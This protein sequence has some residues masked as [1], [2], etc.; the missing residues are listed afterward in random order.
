MSDI[1]DILKEK[2]GSD[3]NIASNE[4]SKCLIYIMSFFDPFMRD[5]L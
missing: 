5:T 4:V 1:C 2:Y 3:Y